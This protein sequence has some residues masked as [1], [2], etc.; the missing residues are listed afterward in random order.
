MA[1]SPFLPPPSERYSADLSLGDAA[2]EFVQC[3]AGGARLGAFGFQDPD[4]REC[5]SRAR[6]IVRARLFRDDVA[7][8]RVFS[9]R[10]CAVDPLRPPWDPRPEYVHWLRSQ[11]RLPGQVVRDAFPASAG[12]R[13]AGEYRAPSMG[14][15]PGQVQPPTAVEVSVRLR[16]ADQ[17]SKKTS[18]EV[19]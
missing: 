7:A 4:L 12:A 5:L 13:F 14:S 10:R 1:K 19:S 18:E 9:L 17:P 16:D 8:V 6:D 3:A 2:A 11:G 15:R